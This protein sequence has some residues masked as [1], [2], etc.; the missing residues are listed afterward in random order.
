MSGTADLPGLSCTTVS[1][2]DR[3]QLTKRQPMQSDSCVDENVYVE[4]ESED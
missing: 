2:A 4:V 1:V 3:E